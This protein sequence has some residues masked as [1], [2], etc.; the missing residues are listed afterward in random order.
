MPPAAQAAL[1]RVLAERT[2]TP[3]GDERPIA[4]DLAVVSATHRDLAAMAGATTFR[5]DLLARLRGVALRIPPLRERRE[6]IGAFVARTLAR[7]APGATLQVDAARQV[8]LAGWPLNVREL[9]H[10]VAAAALRAGAR[11]VAAS[12]LEG[13]P[14]L[15]RAA[16][17]QPLEWSPADAA[18]RVRLVNALASHGGNISAVARELGRDRKQIHRWITRLAIDAR[19]PR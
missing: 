17:A 6:D 18:L 16:P 8:L 19:D 14:A 15:P 3:V 11:A 9:E 13:V 5:S 4:V 1:L 10:V 12:D 7:V 2:V